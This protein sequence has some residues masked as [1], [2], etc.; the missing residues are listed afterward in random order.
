M[1]TCEKGEQGTEAHQV[2]QFSDAPF[3]LQP[4]KRS[5]KRGFDD[6]AAN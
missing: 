4:D 3:R 6:D 1:I 5:A 2:G